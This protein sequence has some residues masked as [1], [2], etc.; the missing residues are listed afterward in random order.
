MTRDSK[1]TANATKSVDLIV[2][3]GG[4][5]GVTA[6]IQA[7]QLDATVALLEADQVGGTNLNRGPA[8]VR[9]M[10]RSARLA[11]DW[12]SWSVFGLEGPPPKPNLQA[13]LANSDRVARHVFE[14]KHLADQ[15]RLHGINLVEH[16]GPVE[17]TDPHTLTAGDGRGWRADRIILAVGGHAARLAIP[18]SELALTYN[19]IRTLKNLPAATAVVGAADTG[20]QIASILAD[21]GSRVSLF[22]AGQRLVPQADV[23]VSSELDR[24]FRRKGIR[25]HT[26]T[27]VT[28]LRSTKDGVMV[29]YA[30]SGSTAETAVDAVFFAVGWPP[31]IGQLGLDVA[32]IHAQRQGI[33]VD[34]YLRTEVGHI[35]AAGDVNGRSMLVQVARLEGRIAAQNALMG[36]TRQVSYDIVPSASFTDPEYGGVGLTETSAAQDHE[37]VVGLARYDDLLRPVADGHQEGFCKL[38]A[39]RHRKTILGGHV[40]G[41]YSAEIIQVIVACMAAGMTIDQVA[42]LPFAFPTFTEGISMAAQKICSEIGIGDFPPVWSYLGPDD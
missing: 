34:A 39:D 31:N 24:A 41:E 3:G 35:F 19:D 16:L 29:E 37:I 1:S 18:G 33:S 13:I 30:T 5:A 21:L 36:P 14:K 23:S 10:A 26:N 8:P 9:T 6:A 12:T 25:T 32:G 28:A 27:A 4:P 38:I 2:V 15:F 17:F 40:L 11:R 20:C 7:R 42:E 22:E